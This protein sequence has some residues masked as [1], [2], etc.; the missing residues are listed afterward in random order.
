QGLVAESGLRPEQWSLRCPMCGGQI[1]P[2]LDP[3]LEAPILK[4]WEEVGRPVLDC[5]A[6][7]AVFEPSATIVDLRAWIQGMKP[8]NLE[9]AYLGQQLWPDVERMLDAL[10]T[11]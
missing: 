1:G 8:S 6:A 3:I 9:M 7:G 11:A 10:M 2:D 5:P 4:R